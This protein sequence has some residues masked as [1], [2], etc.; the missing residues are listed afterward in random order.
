MLFDLFARTLD[1]QRLELRRQL[2]V[3][4]PASTR[5]PLA[6]LALER[7]GRFHVA[8][9]EP[10][11]EEAQCENFHP[12]RVDHI[13]QSESRERNPHRRDSAPGLLL[14]PGPPQDAWVLTPLQPPV[15][16]WRHLRGLPP[17]DW[18]SVEEA[19]DVI[20]ALRKITRGFNAQRGLV[21]TDYLE[22]P[23]IL[24][25]YLLVFAPTSHGQFATIAGSIGLRPTGRGRALDLGCGPGPVARALL[26]L[27][28][29][30]VQ[31]VDWSD[32]ALLAADGL[33]R[34][35]G[36][37]V[38]TTRWHAGDPLPPGL[39]EVITAGHLTNELHRNEERRVELR[40]A[41]VRRWLGSLAP[42]GRL[43]LFEPASH[44]INRE[45]LALRDELARDG[46]PIHAPCF[47]S[48]PCPALAAAGACHG[49]L[50]WTPPPLLARLSAAAHLE[51]ESM[52]FSW[53]VL[54]RPDEP[55][56]DPS[57]AAVRI[58]SEEMLNKAGRQRFVVCGAKGRF[59]LSA[60]RDH[61]RG[62]GH[63][64][65]S[66]GR[67]DAVIVEAPEQRE[68]GWGLAAASRLRP[69]G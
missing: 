30:D 12:H 43:I 36:R 28:F 1:G 8:A 62:W 65:R 35:V 20:L 19:D 42:G 41:H 40:A 51:R 38:T 32:R 46:V 4:R 53:L 5:E 39:F 11:S 21:G 63:D 47:F 31:A 45:F 57:P 34:D 60:P 48:G 50:R 56:P 37:R 26:E 49:E 14:L 58:V 9:R 15:P 64:W 2:H 24:G 10:D 27:G 29:A 33:A 44:S 59:S 22:D 67:G 6:V 25:A 68:G 3:D 66:L 18:L 16:L 55:R 7:Q 69:L 23:A 17:R 52:A 54:G 13:P 61:D